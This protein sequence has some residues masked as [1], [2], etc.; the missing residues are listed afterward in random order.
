M[1][2]TLLWIVVP[3]VA[4]ATFVGGHVWRLKRGGLDRT[5]RSSQLLE[6]RLLRIGAP[7]FHIGLLAVIGGHVLGII[8]PKSATEAVGVDEHL[9][10]L[11]SVSAGTASG[12]AMTAGFLVLLYRRLRVPRVAATTS[13]TDR[14]VYLL[15]LTVIATG[16]LATVGA[17][18]LGGGY[19][20]RETV[21]PWFR[22]LFGLVPDA[23]LM[24]GAPL[25][26]QLHALATLALFA[27]WPF[28]RLVHAWSVP[29]AY[30][31]RRAPILYRARPAPAAYSLPVPQEHVRGGL[32]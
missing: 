18:L 19:D 21:A 8:V 7:L 6:Q 3:Y 32:R 26:Y 31:A 14:A 24:A 4:L 5:T 29:L 1:T 9:Y 15:L 28:S 16:M 23:A 27:L 10:H 2:D 22:G 30:L 17:N 20:Y 11:V 13:G 12:A 25:V